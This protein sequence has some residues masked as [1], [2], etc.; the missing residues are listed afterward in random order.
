MASLPQCFVADR[1]TSAMDEW[2]PPEPSAHL[3]MNLLPSY[4]KDR[5]LTFTVLGET[6][7]MPM[8]RWTDLEN[9]WSF[10]FSKVLMW[11]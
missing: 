4:P 9:V 2:G 11:S 1:P 10:L 5:N 6:V 7:S 8:P 3:H